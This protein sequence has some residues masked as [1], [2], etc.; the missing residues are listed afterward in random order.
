[1]KEFINALFDE[2]NKIDFQYMD[3]DMSFYSGEF[4]SYYLLFYSNFA[5]IF[6]LCTLKIQYLA[7]I[8]LSK[9]RCYAV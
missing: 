8:Q 3:Y 5:H 2:K 4:R 9:F 1:M 7:V 6:C